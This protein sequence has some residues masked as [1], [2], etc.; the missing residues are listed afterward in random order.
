M[1]GISL[2]EFLKLT[3]KYGATAV[4]SL[5]LFVNNW[6][7]TNLEERLYACYE[8]RAIKASSYTPRPIKTKTF[9]LRIEAIIPDKQRF[10]NA[11]TPLPTA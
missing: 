6:R 2:E 8:G 10:I 11:D 5:W 7:L 9:V 4:L 3:K 1:K